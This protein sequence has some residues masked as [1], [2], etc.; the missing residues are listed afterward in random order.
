MTAE[1]I[2]HCYGCKGYR[3]GALEVAAEFTRGMTGEN[4]QLIGNQVP[5]VINI[6]NSKFGAVAEL[7][8]ESPSKLKIDECDCA[9]CV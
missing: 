9:M 7:S 1:K 5:F 8:G 4:I 3:N 2:N 6:I